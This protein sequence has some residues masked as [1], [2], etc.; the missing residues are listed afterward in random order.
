MRQHVRITL[1]I[2]CGLL[3]AQ[4]ALAQTAGTAAQAKG[5][6]TA[7]ASM[8][9]AQL[10]ATTQATAN[11]TAQ[12][13]AKQLRERLEKRAA[14]VSEQARAK[15][16]T[17][18]TATVDQVNQNSASDG[19]ATVATRLATEFGMSP[20]AIVDERKSLDVGWGQ[21]MIAHT[22]AANSN[23]GVTV[24]QLVAMNKDGMGWSQIAAG[25]GLQLGSVVSSVN[26]ESR[27]A[28]GLE[29]ADGRVA[30]MRG[31]G[32]RPGTS[33]GTHAGL[34]VQTGKGAVGAGA[35]LGIKINH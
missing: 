24:E 12:V 17:Q 32:A 13:D 21:L 31:E 5:Q 33:I 20:E 28:H 27:V 19:E 26:A 9:P 18:L 7:D 10:N 4:L 22:L 23:S 8:Q 3:A 2:G 30:V 34:G 35:G 6:S 1:A 14:K 16:Q 29:K 15:A 11:A 25:L